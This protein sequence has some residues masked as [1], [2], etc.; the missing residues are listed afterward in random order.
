MGSAVALR[1]SM[2]QKPLGQGSEFPGLTMRGGEFMGFP[3][4]VSN[5][6][7]AETVVFLNTSDV[8]FGDEG[9]FEVKM[10]GEASLEMLDNPVGDSV[11][12]TGA[13]SMVSMFQTNSTAFLAERH[14]NWMKRRAYAVQLLTQVKWG[15]PVPPTPGG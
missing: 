4:I 5:Y 14:L 11:A 2:L 15:Q 10:S 1:A 6:V 12:P 13:A 8:Y 3:A 7:P 9:G